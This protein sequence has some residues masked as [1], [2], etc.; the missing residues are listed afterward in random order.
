M[1]YSPGPD[2]HEM[3]TNVF[4]QRWADDEFVKSGK[5]PEQVM[6][7][8]DELRRRQPQLDQP[9]GTLSRPT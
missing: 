2:S 3:F 7:V 9:E 6:F 1:N 8:I 5:W 4:V